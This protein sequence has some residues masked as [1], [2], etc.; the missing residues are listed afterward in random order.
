MGMYEVLFLAKTE[1]VQW[2]AWEPKEGDGYQCSKREA[3]RRWEHLLLE[4]QAGRAVDG[5]VPYCIEIVDNVG[6][7]MLTCTTDEGDE[8]SG[9][10]A[11][12]KAA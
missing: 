8:P 1:G 7:V 4:G 3:M 9:P 5:A 11:A 10:W 12:A 2:I 6:T